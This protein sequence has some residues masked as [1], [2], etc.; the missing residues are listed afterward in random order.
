MQR[1]LL[2]SAA[3]LRAQRDVEPSLP[4]AMTVRALHVK[5]LAS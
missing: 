5:V 1:L 2:L 3:V 4:R